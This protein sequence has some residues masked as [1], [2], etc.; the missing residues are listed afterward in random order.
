MLKRKR[1]ALRSMTLK[2]TYFQLMKLIDINYVSIVMIISFNL[3][4]RHVKEKP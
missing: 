2:A 4:D 3:R 1:G